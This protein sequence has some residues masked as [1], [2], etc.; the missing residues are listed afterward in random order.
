LYQTRSSGRASS[1]TIAGGYDEDLGPAPDDRLF[2]GRAMSALL[3]NSR[4]A[5][6]GTTNGVDA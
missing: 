4:A 5:D 1:C 6:G 3:G 2:A